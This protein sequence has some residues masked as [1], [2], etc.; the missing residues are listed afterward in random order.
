MSQNKY[1]DDKP[2]QWDGKL[3]QWVGLAIATGLGLISIIVYCVV[4]LRASI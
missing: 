2:P 3:P 1:K 4:V